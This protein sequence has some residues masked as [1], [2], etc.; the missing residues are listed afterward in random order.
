[1]GRKKL[2]KQE[3]VLRHLQRGKDIDCYRAFRLFGS[4]RLSG[5]IFN[6]RKRGYRI[7]SYDKKGKSA[8]GSRY[9]YT[10][11]KMEL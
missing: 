6:L 9:R 10:V 1:M 11:Y 8:D 5:I 7:G 3:R 2:S 4:M